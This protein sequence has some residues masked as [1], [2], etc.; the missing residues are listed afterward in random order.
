MARKINYIEK[1]IA[2]LNIR[3]HKTKSWNKKEL[4][5]IDKQLEELELRLKHYLNKEHRAACNR[6]R[7]LIINQILEEE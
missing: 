3:K 4:T 1:R 5:D 7:K 2:K 6:Q